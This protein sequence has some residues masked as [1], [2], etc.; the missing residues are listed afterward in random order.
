MPDIDWEVPHFVYTLGP[1]FKPNKIVRTGKGIP[2]ALRVFAMLDL[3]LTS[4]TIA[5]A[6][7]LSRK[8]V[9]NS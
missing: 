1:A 5:E 2:M 8:R 6:H 4:D 9:E 3:L 7:Y